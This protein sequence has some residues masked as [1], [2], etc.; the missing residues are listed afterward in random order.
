MKTF[1]LLF[2]TLLVANTVLAQ[3][4]V[5]TPLEGISLREKNL[6]GAIMI[7]VEGQSMLNASNILTEDCDQPPAFPKPG[8]P[9]TLPTIECDNSHPHLKGDLVVTGAVADELF[10]GMRDVK[11]HP[12]VPDILQRD[13]NS[14]NWDDVPFKTGKNIWCYQYPVKKADKAVLETNCRITLD[15]LN[16]GVIGENKLD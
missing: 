9:P 10:K 2:G 3:A 8:E 1:T 11:L 12:G 5:D 6:G 15:D 14:L 13:R 7:N 16:N 4:L